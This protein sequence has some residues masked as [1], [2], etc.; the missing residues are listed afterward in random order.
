MLVSFNVILNVINFFCWNVLNKSKAPKVQLKD[1]CS[2]VDL[3]KFFK[4]DLVF[5][6]KYMGTMIREHGYWYPGPGF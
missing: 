3:S 6:G 5:Y 4:V 2:N 1:V